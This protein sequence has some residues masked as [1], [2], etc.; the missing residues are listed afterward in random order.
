MIYAR[1]KTHFFSFITLAC[2]LPVVFI[3]GILWRPKFEPVDETSAVLFHRAGFTPETIEGK[4]TPI[5]SEQLS[6]EGVQ[7]KAETSLLKKY[8]EEHKILL[9]LEPSTAIVFPDLLVYWQ[10][11]KKPPTDIGERSILL[12]KLAGTSRRMFTLPQG[13]EGKEG[14][15]ILYSLGQ[16]TLVSTIPFPSSMTKYK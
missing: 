1:R 13:V 15:L 6:A 8:G 2:V 4:I 10:Q 7:L 3:A 14:Y 11:G 9:I 5:A 16:Q 12:G